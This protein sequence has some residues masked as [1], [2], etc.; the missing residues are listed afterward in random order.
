M[1]KEN[2]W[3]KSKMEFGPI[4]VKTAISRKNFLEK[5]EGIEI[6]EGYRMVL[7]NPNRVI[8]RYRVQGNK[9]L[10]Q[11]VFDRINEL[12]R[13]ILT[14]NFCESGYSNEQVKNIVEYIISSS[15]L[16]LRSLDPKDY[17]IDKNLNV[18]FHSIKE[19]LQLIKEDE[20]QNKAKLHTLWG[21]ALFFGANSLKKHPI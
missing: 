13:K 9:M 10:A 5:V 18:T 1:K 15:G 4:Y 6:T 3:F 17:T 21:F 20:K 11:R 2:N 7:L 16:V 19:R 12:D 8:A 14:R